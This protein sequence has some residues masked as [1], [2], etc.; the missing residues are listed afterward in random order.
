MFEIMYVYGI[1][2]TLTLSVPTVTTEVGGGQLDL[3]YVSKSEGPVF[4]SCE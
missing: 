1:W 3:T 2:R 4:A